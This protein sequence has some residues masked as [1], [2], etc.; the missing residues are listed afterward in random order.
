MRPLAFVGARPRVCRLGPVRWLDQPV[1]DPVRE[2][3]VYPAR[4]DP[5]REPL[6]GEPP[7]GAFGAPRTQPERDGAVRAVAPRT[8][9]GDR[10]RLPSR[11]SRSPA[12]MARRI[13]VK[14]FRVALLGV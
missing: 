5:C 6:A 13:P 12:R 11:R 9:R 4:V 3:L 14:R 1:R 10:R 7:A 8:L 2:T